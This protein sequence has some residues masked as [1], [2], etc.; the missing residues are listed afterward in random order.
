[1]ALGIWNAVVLWRKDK[2]KVSIETKL[3]GEGF[4]FPTYE[5]VV[6]NRSGFPVTLKHA[7][8]ILKDG[9]TVPHD[10]TNTDPPTREIPARGSV[11][12]FCGGFEGQTIPRAAV[13]YIYVGLM[14]GEQFTFPF[15][16]TR[17]Y[18]N[19]RSQGRS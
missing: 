10:K 5:V 7:G 15:S 8:L 16:P 3:Y 2:P 6:I 1:L 11:R 12:V 9:R 19:E 18:P 14:T 13:R 4:G 17:E